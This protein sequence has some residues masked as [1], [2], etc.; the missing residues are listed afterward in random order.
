MPKG[1]ITLLAA[2]IVLAITVQNTCP[3][4]YA[5][6][7]AVAASHVHNCPLKNHQPAN[8]DGSSAFNEDFQNFNH[9]YVLMASG[10]GCF[11]EFFG[12]VE[13]VGAVNPVNIQD[14]DLYPPFKPPRLNPPLYV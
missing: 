14:A 13:G 12:P 4:G 11:L 9:A 3:Y 8:P 5:G 10:V 7:T 2:L 1:L 6:K